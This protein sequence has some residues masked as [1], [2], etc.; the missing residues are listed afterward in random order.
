MR[1]VEVSVWD[2]LGTEAFGR[3]QLPRAVA[4]KVL[5]RTL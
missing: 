1:S 2:T 5:H 4:G 3:N